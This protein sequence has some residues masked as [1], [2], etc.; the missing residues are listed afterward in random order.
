[1]VESNPCLFVI[2]IDFSAFWL[3]NMPESERRLSH[4]KASFDG[5]LSKE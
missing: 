3:Y 4:G 2:L 1:M 5:T